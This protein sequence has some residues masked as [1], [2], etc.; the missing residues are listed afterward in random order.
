MLKDSQLYV[1]ISSTPHLIR[2][3]NSQPLGIS[4]LIKEMEMARE[5]CS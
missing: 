5:F 4:V 3:E 2:A 1:Q